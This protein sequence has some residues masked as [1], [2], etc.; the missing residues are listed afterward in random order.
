MFPDKQFMT[1]KLRSYNSA[2]DW[3]SLFLERYFTSNYLF[4]N[5]YNSIK[6][7]SFLFM[8]LCSH[9]IFSYYFIQDY[10][11]RSLQM[12]SFFKQFLCVSLFTQHK[13]LRSLV[14][15]TNNDLFYFVIALHNWKNLRYCL[16]EERYFDEWT[17]KKL[18]W[19]WGYDSHAGLVQKLFLWQPSELCKSQITE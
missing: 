1:K 13:L 12:L 9:L 17:M 5:F 16:V 18:N 3:L 11:L 4:S 15:L 19:T 8:L 7:V 10:F 14:L 2:L 6:S